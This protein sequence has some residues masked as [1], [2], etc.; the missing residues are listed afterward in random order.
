MI[1]TELVDGCHVGV[2][3]FGQGQRF[4]AEL[5]ARGVVG[6]R[7]GRQDFDSDIALELFIVQRGRI[8]ISNRSPDGRESL[9]ALLGAGELFGEMSLF[10]G[11]GRS[12]RQLN[13]EVDAVKEAISKR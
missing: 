3:K 9:V 8:A 6:Q 7:T 2:I 1:V 12:A 11:L 4:F 5:L 10:D 13:E